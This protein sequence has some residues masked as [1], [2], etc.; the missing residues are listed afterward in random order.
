MKIAGGGQ[1]GTVVQGMEKQVGDDM[2]NVLLHFLCDVTESIRMGQCGV[3]VPVC[4]R[5]PCVQKLKK[6]SCPRRRGEHSL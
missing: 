2:H 1:T 6:Q 5:W 3:T 4:T